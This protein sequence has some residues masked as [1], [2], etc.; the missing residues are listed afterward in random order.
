MATVAKA[1]GR[2]RLRPNAQG[3]TLLERL[4]IEQLPL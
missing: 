1:I 3:V 4:F 2:A